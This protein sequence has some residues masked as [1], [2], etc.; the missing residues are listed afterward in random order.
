MSWNESKLA[1]VLPCFISANALAIYDVIPDG[2]KTDWR[3]FTTEMGKLLN[4]QND[5]TSALSK[6]LQR[7][8]RAGESVSEFG[9]AIRNLVR[10]AYTDAGGFDDA[11]RV[12][13]EILHFRR[14]FSSRIK[15]R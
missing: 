2:V 12:Q 10:L 14:G 8:Q 15:L 7:S 6:L 5:L 13:W 3:Q 4:N 11:A 9:M 1:Q